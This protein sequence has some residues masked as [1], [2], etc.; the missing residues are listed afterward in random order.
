MLSPPGDIDTPGD[1]DFDAYQLFIILWEE[2]G[3]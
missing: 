3:S 1:V 2:E